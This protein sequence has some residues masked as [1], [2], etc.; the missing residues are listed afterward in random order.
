[1]SWANKSA[2]LAWTCL[3]ILIMYKKE[4]KR[5][6]HLE[7]TKELAWKPQRSVSGGWGLLCDA[8][9]QKS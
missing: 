1:M 6:T 2:D 9:I 8:R 4:K 5:G 3:T 7:R